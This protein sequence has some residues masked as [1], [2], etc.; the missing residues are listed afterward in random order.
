LCFRKYLRRRF[1]TTLTASTSMSSTTELTTT[2]ETDPPNLMHLRPRA[3]A[4]L[5]KSKFRFPHFWK[6]QTQSKLIVKFG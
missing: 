2:Y 5:V 4:V 6:Y 1:F 3:Q